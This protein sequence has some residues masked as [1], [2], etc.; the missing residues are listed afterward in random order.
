MQSGSPKSGSGGMRSRSLKVEVRLPQSDVGLSSPIY[1]FSLGAALR[2]KV[3][4][5]SHSTPE[6]TDEAQDAGDNAM[7]E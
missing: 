3:R 4:E 1:I 5:G 2:A 6:P 7:Q